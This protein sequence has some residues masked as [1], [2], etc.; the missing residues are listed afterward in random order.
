VAVWE[1]LAEA[2]KQPNILIAEY[3]RRLSDLGS[4]DAIER[5]QKQL[6]LAQKRLAVQEDR[7]TEAYVNEAMELNRYKIEMEKLRERR[8]GLANMQNQMLR[9]AAQEQD[10]NAGLRYL[11]NFC[12][13]VSQSLENLTYEDRQKLLLLVVERI[14]VED[15]RVRIETIIPPNQG[16]QLRTRRTEP[17]EGQP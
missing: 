2:L 9:K 1:A 4:A 3:E 11:K 6:S 17:V 7:I 16:V 15:N 10:A 13:R 5:E 8:G 12:D 14:T